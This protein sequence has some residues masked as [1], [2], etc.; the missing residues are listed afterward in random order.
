[1]QL[2]MLQSENSAITTFQ[3]YSKM[4]EFYG[5]KGDYTAAI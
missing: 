2:Q 3:S 1:M 5:T 4:A